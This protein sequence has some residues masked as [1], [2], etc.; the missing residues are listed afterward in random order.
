MDEE[1]KLMMEDD[2]ANFNKALEKLKTTVNAKAGGKED[3][4]MSIQLSNN[5]LM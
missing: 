2:K 1:E 5:Q 3:A 4:G